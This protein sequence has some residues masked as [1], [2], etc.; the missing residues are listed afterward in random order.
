[1]TTRITAMISIM[2]AIVKTISTTQHNLLLTFFSTKVHCFGLEDELG[3]DIEAVVEEE[4]E[5]DFLCLWQV[6]SFYITCYRGA[7]KNVLA[8]FY[9]G[10]PTLSAKGFLAK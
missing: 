5:I 10:V 8:D 2:P 4:E 9:S 3:Q 6:R 7:V 1:M